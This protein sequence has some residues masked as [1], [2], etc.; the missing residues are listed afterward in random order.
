[1]NTPPPSP[2][3]SLADALLR[4]A[5]TVHGLYQQAQ[6]QPSSAFEASVFGALG[7]TLAFDAA[8]LGHS[9]LAPQG[10]QMHSSSLHQLPPDYLQCWSQVQT[11]DPLVTWAQ[12]SPTQPTVLTV[13][14]AHLPAPFRA[15]LASQGIAQILCAVRVDASVQTCLHVSLYRH[16]LKPAFHA[17]DQARLQALMPNL[18]GAIALSRMREVEN[19]VRGQ[20]PAEFGVALL[21][22]QGVIQVTNPSFGEMLRREWPEWPGATLPAA[23]LRGVGS[24]QSHRYAGQRVGIELTARGDLLIATVRPL[25]RSSLLTARERAVATQFAQGQTYKAVARSLEIA[26]ATVRHHLRQVYAK[27]G[28]QDKGAIAWAL[29]QEQMTSAGTPPWPSQG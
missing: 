4:M 7:Q 6:T 22:K 8:W 9:T 16:A 18:A 21:S 29:S 28:V 5:Q 3:P 27:L 12:S 24:G 13:A 25:G 20:L 19:A 11:L 10:A 26:P 17:D 15:F 14:D 2:D 23:A 1:M